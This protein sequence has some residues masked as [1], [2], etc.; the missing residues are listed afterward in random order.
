MT[1]SPRSTGNPVTIAAVSVVVALTVLALKFIAYRLTGSIALYS[2]ALE[3]IINVVAAGAALLALWVSQRPADKTHP[4]GHTKAEYLSA[5]VEGVL[6]VLAAFSILRVAIPDLLN[7]K[8]VEA[9]YLGMGVNLGASVLNFLWASFLLRFGR[10]HRSPALVA[11]GKHVMSD[12]VTSVGVLI[13]VVAAKLT[14]WAEL[15]PLLAILVALNI[16]WSGWH[17]LSDSVGGLMDKGVDESTESRIRHV[18]STHASGA[19]EMHDL[20]TRHSGK[21]TFVEFHLVVP[22]QM[23]VA[24]AHAICDRLEEA[25]TNELEGAH[26]TI[27]VE[28][29]ENAKHHGVLVI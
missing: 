27:H 5:V 24:Q 7:P 19:L 2:D 3:S 10:T 12:V 8:P 11:D 6:I 28:P 14:G 20:R 9:T 4:Y 25:V 21:V 23:T 13:G 1:A 17:L 26:V 16:L 29:E 18:M 22:G 15:D